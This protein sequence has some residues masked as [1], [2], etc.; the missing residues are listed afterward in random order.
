[1]DDPI[2]C[3][4]V[5]HGD[6]YS[7]DYVIRLRNMICRHMDRPVRFHVF[8]EPD[9]PVPPPMIRHDLRT[10]PGVSGRKR[11]WWYKMQMFDPRHQLDRFLYLDLDVVVVRSLNWILDLDPRYFW[12]V[13]DFRW[14][15]RPSW[16]G[17]NTSVMYWDASRWSEIWQD[18]AAR[19]IN[20]IVKQWSGDQ[21][22][23]THVMGAGK[24]KFVDESLVQSWRWQIQDGGLDF[25]TRTYRRPGAGSVI[26]P[27][28]SVIVFHGA[29]KPHEIRDETIQNFW[30]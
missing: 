30:K 1:M 2:D 13:R 20:T 17:A 18:F 28:V 3:G 10:W 26:T 24:M 16:Q 25:R 5:I 9:R 14:L 23:I 21:D 22:Y 4:C 8:T 11:G 27:A 7:W 29:P 6:L 12:T 19:D 15:W